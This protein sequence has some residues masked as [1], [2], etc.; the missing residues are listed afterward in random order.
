MLSPLLYSAAPP[1]L[2]DG[3]QTQP[4]CDAAGNQRVTIAGATDGDASVAESTG[5]ATGTGVYSNGAIDTSGFGTLTW[6]FSTVGSGSNRYAV[7]GSNDGA[8]WGNLAQRTIDVV[9]ASSEG[10]ASSLVPSTTIARTI[11]CSTKFIRFRETTYIGGTDT[12]VVKLRRG[13]VLGPIAVEQGQGNPST[14]WSVQGNVNENGAFSSSAG[15]QP[16][17]EARTSIKSAGSNGNAIRPIGTT[18]GAAIVRPFQV[19][20]LDLFYVPPAG[21]IVN[22]TTA[23]TIAPA[24]GAGARNYITGLQLATDALGGATELV[25]RDGA[26]GTVIWRGKLQ[27]AALQQ[28]H[29]KF[30]TPLKSSPN[31]LLEVATLTAVTGGV[32]VNAQGYIAP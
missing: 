32:Y 15:H 11:P 6:H 9:G 25:I 17:L 13:S 20:E 10:S 29:I 2:A 7:E 12:V 31:T 5:A 22:T 24:A 19:P 8:N 14:P 27:T 26:A 30:P 1:T 21:G 28:T 3:Q 16:M 18:T 4:L 23:V